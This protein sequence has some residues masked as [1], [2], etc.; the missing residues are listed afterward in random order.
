MALRSFKA[1]QDVS[2]NH[3]STLLPI[4]TRCWKQLSQDGQV[5]EVYCT[6]GC[7]V[8]KAR[9]RARDNP[10]PM[11]KTLRGVTVE[12]E[13]SEDGRYLLFK[14]SRG[15]EVLREGQVLH[16][17]G[18]KTPQQH[19]DSFAKDAA[20]AFARDNPSVPCASCGAPTDGDPG[21]LCL[22]CLMSG[23]SAGGAPEYEYPAP[24][25]SRA[26][27]RPSRPSKPAKAPQTRPQ[28]P[29]P[30]L[31]PSRPSLR[32]DQAE[33]ANCGAPFEGLPGGYCFA[34]MVAASKPAPVRAAPARAVPARAAQ[35]APAT[36][37]APAKPQ[38]QA[39]AA[40]TALPPFCLRCGSGEMG[41]DAQGPLCEDCGARNPSK[42]V[43]RLCP[44]CRKP[45][46]WGSRGWLDCDNGHSTEPPWPDLPVSRADF[47]AKTYRALGREAANVEHKLYGAAYEMDDEQLAEAVWRWSK[48][49]DNADL[50]G[51]D[52]PVTFLASGAKGSFASGF[53]DRMNDLALDKDRKERRGSSAGGEA[54][55]AKQAAVRV[56]VKEVS[57]RQ[58][59]LQEFASKEEAQRFSYR[60][61]MRQPLGAQLLVQKRTSKGWETESVVG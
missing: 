47:R 56:V 37:P 48:L 5:W 27:S 55:P 19:F 58:T 39:E 11:S 43:N 6:P 61:L 2:C 60:E 10:A 21:S 4:G 12:G 14:V 24:P 40:I 33:C 45:G 16:I 53:R 23:K 50:T 52:D 32:P 7:A 51:D 31:A 25:A 18:V 13:M 59:A 9:S 28:A 17:R 44:K 41:S 22:A 57:G 15:G 54:P 29:G 42:R 36:K 34:C 3:C 38:A 1:P 20:A 35:V 8:E 30:S 49:W 46:L 26:P